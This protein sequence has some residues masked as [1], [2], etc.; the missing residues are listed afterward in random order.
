VVVHF[1]GREVVVYF[2]GREGVVHFVYIGGIV[3]HH[4]LNSL[5]II[6]QEYHFI[7]FFIYKFQNF[8]F[9]HFIYLIL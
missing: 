2:V 5:F 8:Y 7:I 1:V 4:C 9:N 3:D 6:M